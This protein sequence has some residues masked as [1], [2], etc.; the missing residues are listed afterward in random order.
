ME[1]VFDLKSLQ[2]IREDKQVLIHLTLNNTGVKG[3]DPV[4]VTL[5]LAHLQIQVGS[6]KVRHDLATG[7]PH[8][9]PTANRVY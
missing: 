6:Q 7:Y 4:C 5:Q 2:S 3:A 9:H 8:T 1:L